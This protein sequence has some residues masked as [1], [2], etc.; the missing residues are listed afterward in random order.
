MDFE[1]RT[2]ISAGV[3]PVFGYVQDLATYPGWFSI[4]VDA[5]PCSGVTGAW[6]VDLGARLGPIKRTKRVRMERTVFDAGSHRVRFERVELDGR[7]HSAWTLDAVVT[8]DETG[9]RL[10]VRLHY[11]GVG[12]VPG[13]DLLVR[14]EARRAGGRLERLLAAHGHLR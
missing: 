4:V 12:W 6:D 9:T 8:A 14:E 11:G 3:V 10:D 1:A 2:T 7:D 13:F 5:A